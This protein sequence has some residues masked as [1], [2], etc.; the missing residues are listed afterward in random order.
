MFFTEFGYLGGGWGSPKGL[1]HNLLVRLFTL[2][3]SKIE[4]FETY[5]FDIVIT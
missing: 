1:S 5:F 4:I 3:S 2:S